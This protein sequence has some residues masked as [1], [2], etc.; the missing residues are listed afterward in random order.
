MTS[1]DTQT[2]SLSAESPSFQADCGFGCQAP[3]EPYLTVPEN[4]GPWTTQLRR[5]MSCGL[6]FENPRPP[7]S[8]IEAFYQAQS[9]WTGSTDAEGKPRSYVAELENKKPLF[10]D[11]IQRI[12]RYKTSGTLLDI[13]CG[14]GLLE[15]EMDRR[16]WNV[17]G[18]EM[19]PF[20]CEF[21]RNTLGSQIIEG[22]FETLS[23]PSSAYDVVVFK[24]VLDH[25]QEPWAALRKARQLVKPDGL[26]VLA[27]VINIDSFCARFFGAGHRLIHPMHF[28][29]FSPTTIRVHLRRL[30][31]QVVHID[32]PFVRTPYCSASQLGT[33]AG[34]TVQRLWQRL[35]RQHQ[36]RIYSTAFY[37]NM[38]DVFAIPLPSGAAE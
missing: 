3:S 13:G 23:L 1:V 37:G 18:V 21:G 14:P 9:L 20:I 5:C 19:A 15:A 11:L 33:L 24:Y 29:Y 2:A 32:F 27:D 28:T 6:V 36:P 34:R 26:L 22:R 12:E 30:G 38:M 25:M 17:T 31:F 10:R 7:Q 8:A 4:Q 16:R 35:R